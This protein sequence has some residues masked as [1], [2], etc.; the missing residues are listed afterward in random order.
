VDLNKLNQAARYY[1]EAIALSPQNVGLLN[2][3]ATTQF[4]MGDTNGA[5][6]T[7]KRSQEVDPIFSQTYILRG[8]MFATLGDKASALD[9]Y[10]KGAELAA[11]DPSVLSAVGVYSAQTGDNAGALEAF[12]HLADLQLAGLTGTEQATKDLDT[13][14]GRLGGYSTVLTSASQRREA[15]QASIASLRS[16]LYLTYRNIALVLRDAGRLPEALDA[17]RTALFYA[18]D[19]ERPAVEALITDL[20]NPKK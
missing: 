19:T 10:R 18:S 17:A 12:K 4:I 5:L 14:V 2:E 16:Q 7:L 11:G 1:R 9:A 6:A 8:D 3:L 20:Q 13:L 15:L